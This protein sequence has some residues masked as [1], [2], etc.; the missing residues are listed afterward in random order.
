M[1]VPLSSNIAFKANIYLNKTACPLKQI[2][3]EDLKDI[4]GLQ[5]IKV[6]QKYTDIN[7]LVITYIIISI[8]ILVL[9]KKRF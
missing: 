5:L 6:P 8:S 4:K 3:S 2:Y 1:T 9:L 7:Q